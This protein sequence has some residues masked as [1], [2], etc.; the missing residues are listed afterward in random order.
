M[1]R[2]SLLV[3]V[4]ALTVACGGP[5]ALATAARADSSPAATPIVAAPAAV[6]SDT[7]APADTTPPTS[8]SD[9]PN[10]WRNAPFTVTF[11]ASDDASGVAT[12]WSWLDDDA[13]Q[14]GLQLAVAAPADGSF[15]GLHTLTWY[16]VDNAGNQEAPQTA[17]LRIDTTG[18]TTVGK[19]VAAF[20]GH[21]VKLRYEVLDALSPQVGAVE[22]VLTDGRGNVVQRVALDTKEA[23]TWYSTPWTPNAT[24][25]YHYT[26]SGH[27]LAGNAQRRATPAKVVVKGPWWYTIGH[28]VQHRAI[29]VA[30]FGTGAR[31]LLVVGGVHGDE[32]GTAVAKRFA[33]YLAAHPGAVPA[34]ARIDVIRCANPDGYLHHTRGN[35]RHVDLNRNLP[36]ANWT[37]LLSAGDE[38]GNPGLTGGSSPGSEP[39]TKALLT[40]LRTGFATVVSLH[41]HAGILDCDGP[42]ARALGL[43]MSKL[44]GL[45]VGRLSYDPYITGSLG[46][47]VP[48]RYHVPVVTVELRST[49][50]SGGLRAALLA[51]AKS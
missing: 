31:R 18:P 2:L 19:S 32:Y 45:P 7:P 15:D 38:P 5:L 4:A 43:R 37:R 34:G 46:E 41:S 44:C 13:P 8:T 28:S 3:A 21:A 48:A 27:D 35:A 26:V 22:L 16:A 50:M 29:V 36:T 14:S 10:G 30:R 24:G 25:T 39:E 42:R 1:R 40:Y 47:Y 12:V 11:T 17:V 49:A 23:N 33:A 9:A 51:A 20:T 6:T